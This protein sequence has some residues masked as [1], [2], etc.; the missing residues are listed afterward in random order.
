MKQLKKI[1]RGVPPTVVA[2]GL[3]SMFTDLSSEMIYPLIPVF[4]TTTLGAGALALGVIEG[5]AE[6][7]AA[8][9]KVVSGWWTDTVKRRKPFIFAGY[10][11][12]GAVRPLIAFVFAWPWVLAIRFV[13][14][15]GKGIRTAPRDALIADVTPEEHRGAAYGVHRSLD[16][17]GAVLGPLV[18]AALLG[19]GFGLRS[20]FFLAIIPAVIVIVVIAKLVKEPEQTTTIT[21]TGRSVFARGG[22]LGKNYWV[23]M[24]AVVI[25]TLGNSADA[26][27]LLRLSDEGVSVVWIAILWSL[28]SLVK[29]GSN[30]VGGRLSDRLGRKRLV[31]AGWI[32]YAVIYLSMGVASSTPV[33]I[34]LFLA[35]GLYFGLTEPVERAWVASLAPSDL[36]GSA[37]GYYNGA[38]GIGALPASIVFGG[39]WAVFGPTAAFTFG[40]TMAAIAVLVLFR[41]PEV[42]SVALVD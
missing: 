37:F 21:S 35:Y 36:R 20:V 41:V 30:L 31:L 22:D 24:A 7:T 38:I 1:T 11:I 28:F 25:F 29:M 32:F 8:I 3:V 40:A 23:L 2:L 5:V 33:L 14:R 39:I 19:I 4:L 16:H 18:A 17:F 6:S 15:V 12:A 13:D 10:G 26:F 42:R 27:L 9:L 34:A